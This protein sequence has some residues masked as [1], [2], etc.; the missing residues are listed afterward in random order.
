[1]NRDDFISVSVLIIFLIGFLALLIIK[2]TPKD[3]PLKCPES[4]RLVSM[5]IYPDKIV[6]NYPGKKGMAITQ[7][8]VKK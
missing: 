8:E 6:C 7:V 5:V 3:E 2:S 1:M 4:A